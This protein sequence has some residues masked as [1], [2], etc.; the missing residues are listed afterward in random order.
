MGDSFID[1][2][3]RV[4]PETYKT[5]GPSGKVKPSHTYID[6]IDGQRRPSLVFEDLPFEKLMPLLN[7]L[8]INGTRL[9]D[10]CGE[11]AREEAREKKEMERPPSWQ[12]WLSS[13]LPF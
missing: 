4:Q 8:S 5:A 12:D 9:V 2:D 10:V 7:E 11:E 13:W 6:Y 1:R 3:V